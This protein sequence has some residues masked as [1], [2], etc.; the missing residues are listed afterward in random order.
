MF[1]RASLVSLVDEGRMRI[2]DDPKRSEDPETRGPGPWRTW[3]KTSSAFPTSA[4]SAS[5][6]GGPLR[7]LKESALNPGADETPTFGKLKATLA[8]TL[9]PCNSISLYPSGERG[10]SN[11]LGVV[12]LVQSLSNSTLKPT[13]S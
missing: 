13:W 6:A 3:A 8:E 10:P 7:W 11:P 4:S 2:D 5:A 9:K 1:M 12:H